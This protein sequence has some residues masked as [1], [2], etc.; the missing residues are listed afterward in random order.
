MTANAMNLGCLLSHIARRLPERTALVWRD[1]SW[2]WAALDARVDALASALQRRGIK[3]GDRIL[4]LARNSNQMFETMWASTRIRSP[5][6][7]PRRRRADAR[8]STRALSAAQVQLSSR[9]T[10]AVRSGKRR[11]LW[12]KRH[13]RFI[14]SAVMADHFLLELTGPAPWA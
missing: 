13:P 7:M 14:A 1:E 9:H 12:L 11:A 3:K 10:R 2:T 5:L 6:A 8:A 4:V